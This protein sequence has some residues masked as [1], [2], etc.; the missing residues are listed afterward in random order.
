MSYRLH[1]RPVVAPHDRAGVPPGPADRAWADGPVL[2]V[3]MARSSG[4]G[5]G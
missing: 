3:V 2:V 5:T 1:D 4:L